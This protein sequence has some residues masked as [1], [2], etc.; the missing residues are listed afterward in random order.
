MKRVKRVKC[1]CAKR[2]DVG[3]GPIRPDIATCGACNFAWCYRCEPTPASR[4]PNEI[5]HIPPADLW[6]VVSTDS[7]TGHVKCGPFKSDVA[8]AKWGTLA[9]GSRFSWTLRRQEGSL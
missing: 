1:I 6:F 7:G 9:L 2:P 8:A 5:N 4:C 3:N